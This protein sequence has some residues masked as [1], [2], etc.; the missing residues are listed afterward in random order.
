MT[1]AKSLLITLGGELIN[2]NSGYLEG[3]PS[4]TAPQP[5]EPKAQPDFHTNVRLYFNIDKSVKSSYRLR[6]GYKYPEDADI[7]TLNKYADAL[8]RSAQQYLDRFANQKIIY[9]FNEDNQLNALSPVALRYPLNICS[10]S[11]ITEGI[12]FKSIKKLLT[13]VKSSQTLG[14]N[15]SIA[16]SVL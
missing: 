13:E 7:R 9:A 15:C 3:E 11:S 12:N 1:K 10:L 16:I 4:R 5:E 2:R 14:A 6:G 8:Q